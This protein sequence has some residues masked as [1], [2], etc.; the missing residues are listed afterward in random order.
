MVICKKCGSIS[1]MRFDKDNMPIYK[2]I[3][4]ECG[5]E[6]S[7]VIKDKK[8]IKKNLTEYREYADGLNNS[9]EIPLLIS[10]IRKIRTDIG[11]GQGE[12]SRNLKVTAQ[13]YGTIERC[14]NIP[15]SILLMRLSRLFNVTLNDLY[16]IVE[17]SQEQYDKIKA[18]VCVTEDNR[19]EVKLE[20][21][22][23]FKELENSIAAYEKETG[24]TERKIY[25]NID[26]EEVIKVK[27]KLKELDTEYKKYREQSGA[28]LN[29]DTVIDYYFWNEAIKIIGYEK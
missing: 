22:N 12:A 28:I 11:L 18:L 17:V 1:K 7:I 20:I 23:K 5:Y 24:I 13:R 4:N 15:T 6:E 8:S 3:N 26:G 25:K 27:T 10:N 29:Q 14:Q 19:K 16:D 21:N 2:C 9:K